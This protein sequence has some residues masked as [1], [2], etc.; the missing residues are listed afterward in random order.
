MMSDKEFE[1]YLK[2]FGLVTPSVEIDNK[3]LAYSETAVKEPT[4]TQS[5]W[6]NPLE[7][8]LKVLGFDWIIAIR[9]LL[10]PR[11]DEAIKLTLI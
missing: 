8:V 2:K 5:F 9:W 3:I 10:L 6:L 1:Q 7:T 11:E 4:I